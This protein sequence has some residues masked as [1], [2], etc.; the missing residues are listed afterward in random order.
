MGI[1]DALGIPQPYTAGAI[2]SGAY[3][4][5]KMSP[6]S[7]TT[8]LASSMAGADLFSHIRY[9]LYTT[10]PSIVISLVLYLVIGLFYNGQEAEVNQYL[11]E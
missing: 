7:D 11:T 4:G 6:M 1:G 10:V 8:V 3:F 5:D 2:I 9:M